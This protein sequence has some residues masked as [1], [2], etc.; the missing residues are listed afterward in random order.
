MKC[1]VVVNNMTRDEYLHHWITN[2][3]SGYVIETN[4]FAIWLSGFEYRYS[5]HDRGIMFKA[6]V[7]RFNKLLS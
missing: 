5:H 4:L 6:W 3:V 1:P 7:D 2:L